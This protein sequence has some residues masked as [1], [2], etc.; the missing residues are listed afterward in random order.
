MYGEN[1]TFKEQQ[2]SI[3]EYDP[4]DLRTDL[5]IMMTMDVTNNGENDYNNNVDLLS[6]E[7][8]T[9][10]IIREHRGRNTA[11]K[12]SIKL[13]PRRIESKDDTNHM[14]VN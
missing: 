6:S 7:K 4:L 5:N 13:P 2:I 12:A 14:G 8:K 3:E 1:D 11:V 10:G 9:R